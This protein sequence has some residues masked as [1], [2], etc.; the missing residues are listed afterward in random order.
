[1]NT[2]L[3]R[4]SVSSKVDDGID[5]IFATIHKAAMTGSGDI[6]PEQTV[7]LDQIKKQLVNLITDQVAQ[8]DPKN[9]CFE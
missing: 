8:N 9:D 2:F 6:T 7:D 3:L 4:Q 5:Q 1:M